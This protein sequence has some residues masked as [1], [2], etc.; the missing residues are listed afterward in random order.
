MRMVLPCFFN[1]SIIFIKFNF[2]LNDNFLF[3]LD[4]LSIGSV[5]CVGIYY[6]CAIMCPMESYSERGMKLIANSASRARLGI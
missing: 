4:R 5:I 3:F 2:N 6:V 1:Y